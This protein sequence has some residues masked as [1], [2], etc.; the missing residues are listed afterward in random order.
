VYLAET[1]SGEPVGVMTLDEE[2]V[3]YTAAAFG[4]IRELN[5]AA[6]V[7][8]RGV[9]R[10]LID[11]AIEHSEACGWPRLEVNAPDMPRWART[12]ALCERVSFVDA[13][14]KL[15]YVLGATTQPDGV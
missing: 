4:T 6:E 9:G 14:P 7:R 5:I 11:R 10:M 15:T 3:I 8:S 13:G 1:G 2:M 12:E